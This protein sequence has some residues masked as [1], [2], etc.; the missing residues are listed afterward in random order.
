MLF[1]GARG[2]SRPLLGNGEVIQRVW[3]RHFLCR[4]RGSGLQFE[5]SLS[6]RAFTERH[7]VRA[8]TERHL[9]RKAKGTGWG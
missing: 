6:G 8:F 7:L 9:T 5:K 1:S 2:Y 3:C 4:V